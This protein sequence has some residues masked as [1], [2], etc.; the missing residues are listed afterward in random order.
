VV[1]AI[2]APVVVAAPV[3]AVESSISYI[4]DGM[5]EFLDTEQLICA[6]DMTLLELSK[7]IAMFSAMFSNMPT[8]SGM[9]VA[10]GGFP[11]PIEDA[12]FNYN[13]LVSAKTQA[14]ARQIGPN[15]TPAQRAAAREEL[16]NFKKNLRD[17][18][19]WNNLK[20]RAYGHRLNKWRS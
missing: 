13:L 1:A 6:I 16:R 19:E 11:M 20:Y 17:D 4:Y 12:E 14:L 8:S 2:P 10:G 18:V 15:A 7:I 9:M 5:D 3:A